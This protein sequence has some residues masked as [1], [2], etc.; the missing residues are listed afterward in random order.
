M[1]LAQEGRLLRGVIPLSAL[2][3]L[4]AFITSREGEVSFSLRFKKQRHDGRVRISGE[5]RTCLEMTCQYCL[6]PVSLSVSAAIALVVVQNQDE[7]DLLDAGQEALIVHGEE[8]DQVAIIEDDLILAL[9]MVPRHVNAEG[10]SVCMDRLGYQKP[11]MDPGQD[12]PNP[13]AVLEKL[14]N[15]DQGK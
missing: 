8:I 14:K 13:F 6:E 10:V 4:A 3:R 2:E 1:Q 7:A 15:P 11:L 12:K 9:P 5:V